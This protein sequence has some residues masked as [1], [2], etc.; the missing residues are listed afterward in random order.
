[1]AMEATKSLFHGTSIAANARV[2]HPTQ[3][4]LKR[5][6][7]RGDLPVNLATEAYVLSIENCARYYIVNLR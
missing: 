7:N 1:M 2:I 6:Q 3:V 5:N 4:C